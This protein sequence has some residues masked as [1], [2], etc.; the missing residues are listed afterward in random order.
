MLTVRLN[1][2]LGGADDY[3][4]SILNLA[5]ETGQR[6]PT[7]P[8]VR[9]DS[10]SGSDDDDEGDEENDGGAKPTVIIPKPDGTAEA[11]PRPKKRKKRVDPD[12]EYYDLNDPFIDDSDLGID[13]PTHFAQTK[14]TGFY[15]SS[16]KVALVE[17]VYVTF[18]PEQQY[19]SLFSSI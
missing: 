4:V 13:A 11:K 19:I 10:I 16:G 6:Q 3:T 14:H 15:V 17:D 1:I 12:A 5:K 18:L 2:P 7:P 8:R 9:R